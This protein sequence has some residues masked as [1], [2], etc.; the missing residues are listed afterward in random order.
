MGKF[1]PPAPFI[2]SQATNAVI[3]R[4]ELTLMHLFSQR[5]TIYFQG[6]PDRTYYGSKIRD[7]KA[8]SPAS[9]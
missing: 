7:H 5:Q 1:P 8:V 6:V 9:H 2:G 4:D 3:F